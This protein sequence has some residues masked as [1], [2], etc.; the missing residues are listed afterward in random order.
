M[1]TEQAQKTR[2]ER[3]EDVREAISNIGLSVS[4]D[5]GERSCYDAE[6]IVGILQNDCAL[7]DREVAYLSEYVSSDID[8]EFS[9]FGDKVRDL[10]ACAV[11]EL[12]GEPE[13][14][15]EEDEEDD[16]DEEEWG[17]RQT[18]EEQLTAE[19]DTLKA[20]V[21]ELERMN[22]AFKSGLLV[23]AHDEEQ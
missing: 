3:L 18:V 1:P 8:G 20:R 7:T 17:K 13:E 11:D 9:D 6:D 21:A 5:V 10:L 14:E 4:Y 2:E 23:T 22:A 15:D 19:N 12:E 16:H